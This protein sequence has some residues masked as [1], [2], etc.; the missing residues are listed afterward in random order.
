ML[1]QTW[2]DV[3]TQSF[4]GLWYGVV[5]F[6]PNLVVAVIIFILGWMIGSI[7]GRVVAQI[8][9][10]I[11]VDTALASAGAADVLSRAGLK[12][13]SGAFIGGLV[14]WFFIV[15]FLVAS[16]DVLG[17]AQVNV[18][19]QG[20]VLSYLPNVIVAA[21]ILLVAAVIADAMQKV[22]VGSARAAELGNAHLFGGVTKWAIWVFAVI[23]ALS[24]LGV[25]PAFM[26]VLFTGVVAMLALAG[27]LSFGLGGKEAAAR[28]IEKLRGDISR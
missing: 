24:Q 18:F 17:L 5:G 6:V 4:Q 9:K 8:I 15:V 1:L 19:L 27:G 26:Q 16:F 7:L 20:V 21:L 11:R 3:L 25:A 23:I 13:D 10:A 12:L 22:V 14:K 2:S 28:F